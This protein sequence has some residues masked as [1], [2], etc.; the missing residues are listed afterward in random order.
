V[1]ALLPEAL[2]AADVAT[3][4]LRWDPGLADRAVRADADRLRAIA[5]ARGVALLIED[6]PDLAHG[7]GADGV[8][9]ATPAGYEA[10][11]RRLGP[12]AIVVVGCATRHDAMTAGERGADY[13]AV[14]DLDAAAPDEAILDLIRWWSELMTVPCV[15]AGCSSVPAAQAL[16]AA[17]ADFIALGAPAWQAP[18]G[19]VALLGEIGVATGAQISRLRS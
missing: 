4:L 9:L 16:R 19:L 17:G 14:G 3:L 18:A 1:T 11:R 10:T 5:Q 6:R 15:A 12:A 2:G 7:L 8:H 13:I